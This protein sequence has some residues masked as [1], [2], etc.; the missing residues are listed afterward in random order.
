[1]GIWYAVNMVVEHQSESNRRKSLN[2]LELL[3]GTY[4]MLTPLST[5]LVPAG[6]C[7]SNQYWGHV[8]L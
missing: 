3:M 1:M 6:F 4:E 2:N 7:Y 8:A 5:Y